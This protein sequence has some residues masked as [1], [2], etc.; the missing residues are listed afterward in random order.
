MLN[1]LQPGD[2]LYIAGNAAE[3]ALVTHVVLWTGQKIGQSTLIK[4][5]QIAPQSD[6]DLVNSNPQLCI[7]TGANATWRYQNNLGNWIIADSHYQGPD[8]RAFTQCFYRTQVWGVRRVIGAKQNLRPNIVRTDI[9]TASVNY[10]RDQATKSMLQINVGGGK[11]APVVFDTGSPF[12]VIESP[13]LGPNSIPT[14]LTES[15]SYLTGPVLDAKV[16]FA[17]IIYGNNNYLA[18]NF[19][20]VL[21]VPAGTFSS[22]D[23]GGVLGM[24][25]Y[26]NVSSRLYLP[27]PQ[28]QGFV[29]NRNPNN[30]DE[31]VESSVYFGNLTESTA[32]FYS[33]QMATITCPVL[34]WGA[35]ES[36]L[37]TNQC[38]A[39]NQIPALYT[40]NSA[41]MQINAL[42]DTGSTVTDVWQPSCSVFS[43]ESTFVLPWANNM[44]LK[45]TTPANCIASGLSPRS[46]AGIDAFESHIVYYNQTNGIFAIH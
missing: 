1:A 18:T 12:T 36:Y 24:G 46:N 2:L 11:Y 35:F 27:T 25:M 4:E 9:K 34:N 8:F 23:V 3:S 17:P 5:S 29:I 22:P 45:V 31:F 6:A 10:E 40:I 14:G 7:K 26:N 44:V 28:N 16:Y 43:I 19:T 33:Y 38:Y 20:P 39:S 21:V 37:G 15:F 32:A 30:L 41:P 42:F 13:Y